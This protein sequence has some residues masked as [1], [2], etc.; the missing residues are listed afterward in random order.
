MRKADIILE[1]H[2]KTGIPENAILEILNTFFQEVKQTV[3]R[4][5][6]VSLRHFG[7]FT[8]QLRK[9]RKGRNINAKTTLIVPAFYTPRFRPSREFVDTIKLMK[10]KQT[11]PIIVPVMSVETVYDNSVEPDAK[12][13]A[14][15]FYNFLI[16]YLFRQG[17]PLTAGQILNLIL[18]EQPDYFPVQYIGLKV[19]I[20]KYLNQG[21]QSNVLKAY[22]LG[23]DKYFG[24]QEWGDFEKTN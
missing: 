23:R 8:T 18:K 4:G 16:S 1:I 15:G 6:H 9:M 10:V 13:E 20:L 5:D 19:R 7:T 11:P 14:E 17:K 12:E 21:V 24:F 3:F 2:N 22:F